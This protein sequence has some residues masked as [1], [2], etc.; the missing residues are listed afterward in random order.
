MSALFGLK[1]KPVYV[2]LNLKHF[3]INPSDQLQLINDAV[4]NT[5]AQLKPTTVN[6]IFGALFYL[7]VHL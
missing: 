1:N 3:I 2:S 6:F 4:N 7:S 5:R